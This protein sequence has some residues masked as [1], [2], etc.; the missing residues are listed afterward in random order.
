[1]SAWVVS[2]THIEY[3]IE[4]G[5]WLERREHFPLTWRNPSDQKICELRE[6]NAS[7]IG[8]MLWKQNYMSV[9]YRY[10][11]NDQVE[12]SEPYT[13]RMLPGRQIDPVWTIKAIHCFQYQSCEHPGWETSE[14]YAYC[15]TLMNSM[16][17]CLP[18]YEQA[19]WGIEDPPEP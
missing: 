15:Q 11:E 6:D 8:Q 4:A 5:L 7:Q 2:R 9:N 13:H 3:L 14:A 18:G 16:T 17:H 19:P 1:M 10:D 12:I